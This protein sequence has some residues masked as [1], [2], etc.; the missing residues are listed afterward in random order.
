MWPSYESLQ[1]DIKFHN[2]S[3]LGP[4]LSEI[5]H[6]FLRYICG[7]MYTPCTSILYLFERDTRLQSKHQITPAFY[8]PRGIIPLSFF[9]AWARH[10]G[11]VG[12][13]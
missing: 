1:V 13:R 2:N 8:K 11:N 12:Q 9:N 5:D 10:V 3:K 6:D 7:H 4:K